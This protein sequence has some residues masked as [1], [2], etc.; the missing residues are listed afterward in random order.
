MSVM[1]IN[2]EHFNY[3]HQGLIKASFRREVDEWY[4]Y[5]IVTHMKDRGIDDI[6]DESM[7]LCRSWCDLNKWT[8]C[9]RYGEE[10]DNEAK[11]IDFTPVVPVEPCQFLKH[12]KAIRY[13]IEK[14]YIPHMTV[15]QSSDIALLDELIISSMDAII[16]QI[17][18]YKEAQ[19]N[20]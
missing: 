12:L 20:A 14:E 16:G 17:P 7:R 4:L 18:A 19:W 3:I 1:M 10:Y 13:N 8:Y 2:T 15:S 5:P 11:E 9:N 6:Y